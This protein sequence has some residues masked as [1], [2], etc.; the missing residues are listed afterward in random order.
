MFRIIEV[1]DTEMVTQYVYLFQSMLDSQVGCG[2][3][4]LW[5]G[6]QKPIGHPIFGGIYYLGN[7]CV[8]PMFGC[9]YLSWWGDWS[10]WCNSKGTDKKSFVSCI[11]SEKPWWYSINALVSQKCVCEPIAWLHSPYVVHCYY[12]GWSSDWSYWLCGCQWCCV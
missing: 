10:E 3:L 12:C 6:K 11:L 8:L 4:P 2:F 9:K 5:I 1:A 7:P